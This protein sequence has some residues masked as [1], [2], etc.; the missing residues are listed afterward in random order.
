[1]ITIGIDPGKSG[2]IA[3]IM[4]HDPLSVSLFKMPEEKDLRDLL[5]EETADVNPSEVRVIVEN[6]PKWCGG[7]QFARRTIYGASIASL[8]GSF[9]FAEGMCRGLG[10][11]VQLMAPVKWQNL[12]Q[13]RNV[14]KLDKGP[15]KN[16][17]K[18]RAQKLYPHSKVTLSTA[19]A[20]LIM[21]AGF[22][23]R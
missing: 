23:A 11:N 8:Y 20:L 21:H 16:L 1:M 5:V 14:R 13:C 10:F 19:D 2:G 18:A 7:A 6:I 17:L 22:L 15:W 12:V 9:K 3:M 4:G